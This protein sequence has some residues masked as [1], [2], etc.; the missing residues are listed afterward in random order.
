MKR[1]KPMK[2]TPLKKGSNDL[3]RSHLKKRSDK[4]SAQYVERR[5]IVGRLLK[6]RP[7]CE[8]CMVWGGY[9]AVN[10]LLESLVVHQQMSKDIHELVN[11]SQGGS[12]LE[13]QNLLAVCRQCHSRITRDPTTAETIGL[14]LESWCNHPP[15]YV[16][17]ERLRRDWKNG[18]TTE[19]Y[20][21]DNY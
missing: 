16:E 10:G 2:R 14:H 7:Y 20:W 3:K 21:R 8:A 9:D 13:E 5:E 15:Y 19:P 18:I 6:E 17:A 11:R 1:R 12:I 4:M